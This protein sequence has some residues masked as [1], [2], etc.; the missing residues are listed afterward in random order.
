MFYFILANTPISL[1]KRSSN[2]FL[3]YTQLMVSGLRLRQ[4]TCCITFV[5]MRYLRIIHNRQLF[6]PFFKKSFKNC[7]FISFF[8]DKMSIFVHSILLLVRERPS[9]I[10]RSITSQNTLHRFS[11]LFHQRILSTMELAL[12][13]DEVSREAR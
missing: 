11:I 9:L 7:R 6:R 5:M 12:S 8:S 10:N 4:S 2:V 1:N 13:T 3:L